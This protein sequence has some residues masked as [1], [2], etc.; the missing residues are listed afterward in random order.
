[1][2]ATRHSERYER[3]KVII[4]GGGPAGL[5]TGL[6][7]AQV[8]PALAE[9]TLILEAKQH[10]R[11][12]LCG[13]GITAHGDEQ[14]ARLGLQISVPA[15]TVQQ[16]IF[17]LGRRE[18]NVPHAHAMRVIQ[19]SAF[20]ASLA[21]TAAQRGLKIHTGE[22]LLDLRETSDGYL[23]KT[24]CG[25]YHA[26]VVVGADGA[27]SVV[28]RKLRFAS[29]AGV[30]RLLRVITPVDLDAPGQ[31]PLWA[32]QGAVFDFSCVQRGIQGYLWDFPAY[33]DG[34]PVMNRGIFDSRIA[35]TGQPGPHGHL[36]R[37]FADWL[38]DRDVDL[39][40]VELEGHPV[41]WFSPS[42]EFARPHVLLA[43]DAA[44]VDAL[45]AEGIS[46]AL[47]YGAIIAEMICTAFRQ[48]DFTFADYRERLIKARL[49]RLLRR[50]AA[51]AEAL[52]RHRVPPFWTLFW[53][54][55]ASSPP[56][57]Q[58]FIGESL[59][60]LPPKSALPASTEA[61]VRSG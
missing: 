32:T 35:P 27:N 53:H 6:H 18:F 43:G 14:L 5:A 15:F 23:V 39:D 34:V 7:L 61:V 44:G 47:E 12:K 45:F 10:P 48:N 26:T 36:K 56:W 2:T 20:D 49:G 29:S 46:Y 60:L 37:V 11:P 38:G 59:A 24:D 1:M 40:A 8:A 16:L 22:R 4:V 54:F 25:Q 58:Q 42:A 30:A 57:M 31:N 55:A 52:Y 9:D 13:G 41:R 50:R 17:R 21:E 33:M 19:R 28:R 51:V 3:H